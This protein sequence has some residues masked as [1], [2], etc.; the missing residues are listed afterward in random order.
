MLRQRFCAGDN[1]S[2]PPTPAANGAFANATRPD[3]EADRASGSGGGRNRP[4]VAGGAAVTGPTE[5]V[6]IVHSPL[7]TKN[8]SETWNGN[9]NGG[10]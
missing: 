9:G 5:G 4:A 10:F 3:S 7:R 2:S 1:R 8:A 6:A